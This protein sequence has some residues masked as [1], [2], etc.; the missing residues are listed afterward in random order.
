MGDIMR[1]VSF[2]ELVKRIF[3]EY[4]NQKSIFGI[5]EDYFYKKST[6]QKTKYVL[7]YG[8]NK[9]KKL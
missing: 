2:G 1:P 9:F 6:N 7:L 4:R 3:N 8:S 5:T